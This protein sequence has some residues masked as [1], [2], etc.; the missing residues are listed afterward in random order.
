MR[1]FF[2]GS[3]VD[4]DVRAIVLGPHQPAAIEPA[5]LKGWRRRAAPR[6]LYPI[7]VK[8]PGISV[9]GIV[10]RGLDREAMRRLVL[11]E[12]DGYRLI[13]AAVSVSGRRRPINAWVFV[14]KTEPA[15]RGRPWSLT[16]WQRRHKPAVLPRLRR[17][18]AAALGPLSSAPSGS[19][20]GPA[21]KARRTRSRAA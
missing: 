5:I 21:A 11:Y 7:I 12:D 4:A 19:A 6:R 9:D 2:Y 15:G 8:A 3:L 14:P 13:R 1:F 16:A 10:T 17:W 20:E 18:A